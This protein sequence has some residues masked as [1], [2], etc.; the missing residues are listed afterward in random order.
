[1][2]RLAYS[3]KEICQLL[4]I[5]R[6]KVYDLIKTGRLTARK[7]DGRTVILTTDLEQFLE[8]LEVF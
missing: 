2:S 7:L 1:M 3:I 8:K 4:G 6:S 5:G